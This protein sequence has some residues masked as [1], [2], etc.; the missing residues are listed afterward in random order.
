[1]LD[2]I[3]KLNIKIGIS[4]GKI[5]ISS[6]YWMIAA[7]TENFKNVLSITEESTIC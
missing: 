4:I 6:I 2:L 5:N 3:L 1:M 7:K